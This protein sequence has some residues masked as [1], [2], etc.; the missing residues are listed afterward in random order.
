MS[1]V[2]VLAHVDTA[3]SFVAILLSRCVLAHTAPL[4]YI[5]HTLPVRPQSSGGARG[6]LS[7]AD[8]ARVAVLWPHLHSL[9]RLQV[10]EKL[11]VQTAEDARLEEVSGHP[12]MPLH[13]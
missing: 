12:S 5:H 11:D 13:V 8:L 7:E 2:P 4:P 6:L 10:L 3:P 9:G 1:A